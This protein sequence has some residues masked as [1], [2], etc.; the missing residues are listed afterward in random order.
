MIEE[1]QNHMPFFDMK[2]AYNLFDKLKH[3][4]E[5]LYNNNTTYNYMNFIFTSRHLEYWILNDNSFNE[6]IKYNCKNILN[7]ENNPEWDTIVSLCNREKHFLLNDK[8]SKYERKKIK[9]NKLFDF[10]KINFSDF[11]FT[12]SCYMVE[13]GKEMVELNLVCCKIMQDYKNIFNDN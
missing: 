1:M 7:F 11:S 8:N 3:D 6:T 9:Y 13:V 5:E 4:Y 10:R 2:N 12:T